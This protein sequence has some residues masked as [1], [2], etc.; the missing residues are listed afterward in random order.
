MD[1]KGSDIWPHKYNLF[2]VDVSATTYDEALVAVTR[3]AKAGRSACVTHLAVHGLIEANQ[4]LYFRSML[5]GF[6]TVAPDGMPVKVALNLLYKT[7]LSHNVRGSE[8][9]SRLCE[10]AAAEGIGVFL[11]GSHRHVVD[12]LRKNLI[13]WYPGR[14]IVGCE[15]S[16]FR[17]MTE[18]EEET[19]VQCIND[20]G[21]GLVFLG[22]GCPLQERFAYEHKGR[23]KAV[24]ICV[25]AAF[26]FLSGSKSM[27]PVWIQRCSLE[28]LF[29][30]SQE[31]WRLWR[32]YLVTN[33]IFLSKLLLQ[34]SGLKK[35][36]RPI[37]DKR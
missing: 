8:L 24:Q 32:R 18:A 2:G 22:L 14:R 36:T 16:V 11:Y 7:D 13:G 34:L 9:M 20:S 29:R 37:L 3:A 12:A 28:W 17:P 5:N 33:T 35:Y 10:R 30:L 4:D 25:G 31:P 23:I 15:P 19:L 27:A 1:D 6:D 26:D 21:A